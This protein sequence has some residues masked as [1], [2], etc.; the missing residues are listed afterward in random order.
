M[1]KLYFGLALVFMA[2]GAWQRA[3]SQEITNADKVYDGNIATVLLHARGDQLQIP[4]IELGS[5]DQLMLSFDDLSNQYYAFKYT[6][7]HCD[8]DWQTSDL[9]QMDYLDGYFEAEISDYKFSFNTRMPYIHYQLL[10]P[11]DDMKPKLSGNY[12]LKVYLDDGSSPQV[13]ITRRFYVYEAGAHV[14][15]TLAA[16]PKNLT[17]MNTKQQIDLQVGLLAELADEAAQRVSVNLWQ[18][19]RVDRA[20]MGIHPSSVSS[21]VLYFDFADGLVFDGGNEPRFFDMK[22]YRYLSQ[23]IARILPE[24]DFY[25]VMLH[26]DFPRRGRPYETY[27]NIQG[28]K[29]ITARSDQDPMLE[30][31]YAA[32]Q[33]TLRIEQLE[34]ASVY[35]MGALTDWQLSPQTKMTYDPQKKAYTLQLFLKQGYY[36]Y[37]YVVL[38]DHE[39]QADI[40]PVEGNHWE[41]HNQYT[42]CTYYRNRVPEYD[43]LI[44]IKQFIA[45]Q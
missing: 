36:E 6:F 9:D 45:H 4:V 29:L 33:F 23:S 27:Q 22:S 15:A 11:T 3:F 16:K 35:V 13:M 39:H 30:G 38:S 43:K 42:I 31:D 2:S 21:S 26:P 7:V 32:V 34:Y 24:N 5:D 44:N 20:L 28:R 40:V 12:V 25:K 8:A 19:G 18:N 41:T 17:F 14:S 10:F 37:W 1:K